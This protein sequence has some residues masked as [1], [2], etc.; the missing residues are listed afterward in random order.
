MDSENK[1]KKKGNDWKDMLI[2]GNVFNDL[3]IILIG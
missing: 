3:I 1:R 2:S